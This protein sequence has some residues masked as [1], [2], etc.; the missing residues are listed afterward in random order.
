MTDQVRG[1]SDRAQGWL[2]YPVGFSLL[3]SSGAEMA[4]SDTKRT[5]QSQTGS[6]TKRCASESE[7]EGLF[8]QHRSCCQ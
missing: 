6:P 8:R 2:I 1:L 3:V 7:P 5:R 4:D